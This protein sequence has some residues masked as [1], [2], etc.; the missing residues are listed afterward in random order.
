MLNYYFKYKYHIIHWFTNKEMM[1]DS[2]ISLNYFYK[3]AL[4]KYGL[5][6]IG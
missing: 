3:D 5:L 1:V 6:I 2:K 4:L